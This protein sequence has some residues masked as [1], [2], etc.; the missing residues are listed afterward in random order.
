EADDGPEHVAAC[1]ARHGCSWDVVRMDLSHPPL[2]LDG[3]DLL[4]GLGGEMHANDVARY[5]FLDEAA[6]LL[7]QAVA[8]DVPCL[9]LCLGGQLLAKVMGAEVTRNARL[10]LGLVPVTLDLQR[11]D[12]LLRG[13]E[14]VLQTV[15]FHQDTFGVP[16]G[17]VLLGSSADCRNQIVRCADLA[18]ALQ[19]HPEASAETFRAWVTSAAGEGSVTAS[20]DGDRA[21]VEEVV[22]GEPVVRRQADVLIDNFLSLARRAQTRAPALRI[23][24]SVA[25]SGPEK[26]G[27]GQWERR[28]PA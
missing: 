10:E 25:K 19:F 20:R 17:G 8:R 22:A 3:Y 16:E 21:A 7:G 1:L 26:E 12:P 9:G 6:D 28:S 23:A 18:Y 4:I 15:Q 11:H 24:G 2:A 5:P 13:L 27:G 14:P